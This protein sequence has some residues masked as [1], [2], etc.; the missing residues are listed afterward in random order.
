MALSLVDSSTS[1]IGGDPFHFE[2]LPGEQRNSV[3]RF[4]F[5]DITS[6]DKAFD[7]WHPQVPH[8][9]RQLN[10]YSALLQTCKTVCHEAKTLFEAEYLPNMVL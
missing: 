5:D 4:L 7:V 9:H 6:L 2:D 10:A 3:Y 8:L 1:G